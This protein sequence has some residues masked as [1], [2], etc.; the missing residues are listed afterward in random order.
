VARECTV[1]AHEDVVLINE[2]IV[3]LHGQKSNRAITRQYGL[4]KD[5]VRRHKEHIPELLVKASQ[6]ME[7]ARSDDVLDQ[8]KELLA[9]ARD[10]LAV[11]KADQDH[12]L[13]LSAIDRASKLVELL[14]KIAGQLQQEGTTNILLNAEYIEVRT[15]ILT[16]LEGHPQ[17]KADV[18][19]A[20]LESGNGAG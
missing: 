6:A 4:S 11:A 12:R 13:R 8:V 17:A 14:A 15:V 19:R 5:A 3:G 9:E 20:L 7:V 2:D 16:A 18:V 10:V 1:C